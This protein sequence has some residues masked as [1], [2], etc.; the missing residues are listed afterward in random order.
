MRYHLTFDE[1]STQFAE[2]ELFPML[3]DLCE[4]HSALKDTDFSKFNENEIILTFLSDNQLK[5]IIKNVKDNQLVLAILP[6][7]EAREA[8]IGFGIN[9]NLEKAIEYFRNEVEPINVDIIYCNGRPLF[10]SLV[11]GEAFQL[12]TSKFSKSFSKVNQLK[13]FVKQFFSIQPFHVDIELNEEKTLKTAASG[14]V[15]VQHK[16]SLLLSKLIINDSSVNDGML[17]AFVISPRS[18]MQLLLFGI[19]SLSEQNSL[20]SF[21]A[22]IKTSSLKFISEEKGMDFSEDGNSMSSKEIF[23]EVKPKQLKILPGKFLELENNH[24]NKEIFKTSA[25]PYGEV[26]HELVEKKLPLI[27][28]ASTEEFKDLFTILRENAKLKNT[29]LMLM[30]LSTILATFGLFGNS[31]PVII[32]AMILAPLMAPIISLSMA[33]L[34]QNNQLAI[35]SL[36][37]IAIGMGLAFLFG[38]I[39]ALI[40]P[41]NF[42]NPEILARTRPNILD[43]GIAIVSGIAGAYAHAREEVAKTLAGV[44]IAVALVPP[45]AVSA[46]GLGWLD[47]QIFFGSLLLLLTNLVG[48]V[49][50][51]ALTFAVLGFSPI[52]RAPKS[53]LFTLLAVLILSVPLGFGFSQMVEEHRVIKQLDGWDTSV[54]KVKNV[55]VQRFKPLTISVML[56]SSKPLTEEEIENVKKEIEEKLDKPILLEVSTALKK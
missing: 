30:V 24:S 38:Y 33:T 15:V 44:A 45:L 19:K 34:R 28:Y 26:A 41:L 12:T 16:K 55:H 52:K 56:I 35:Q 13:H 6:H 43:L 20:P 17:H 21:G 50:A 40:T 3:G 42:P 9:L 53:L 31:S 22:H 23:L 25:L 1:S 51:G 36:R 18:L 29:Y 8:C 39:I 32:G 10:N 5:E 48:M 11:I 27:R 46:I 37:T 2:E 14:I 54:A 7:P 47:M 4:S 49:L